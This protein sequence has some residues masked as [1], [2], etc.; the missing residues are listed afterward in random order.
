MAK[1]L[2]VIILYSS[3]PFSGNSTYGHAILKLFHILEHN[4]EFMDFELVC[5]I[6]NY[7]F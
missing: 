1:S 2:S 6:D 3:L 7:S 5:S 4:L